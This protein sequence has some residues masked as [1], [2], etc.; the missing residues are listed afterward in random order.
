MPGQ[1]CSFRRHTSKFWEYWPLPPKV[2]IP[3]DVIY[4][5]GIYLARKVCILIACNNTHV[6][7]WY[8]CRYEN[9]RA[10]VQTISA[11]RI[12][13]RTFLAETTIDDNGTIRAKHERLLKAE[14]SLNKLVHNGN[15][16]TY[17]N[18]TFNFK[19]PTTNNRIEGGVNAQL[20]AMLRNHRGMSIEKRIKAVFW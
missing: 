18:T 5:D 4:I 19:C 7:G 3:S 11:W 10:W 16:F 6:I 12:R 14:N 13:H 2:K 1:G 17:L 8:L 20:R 9:A 15:L